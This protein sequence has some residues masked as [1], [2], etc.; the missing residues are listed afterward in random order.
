MYKLS[1]GDRSLN[2]PKAEEAKLGTIKI[3]A[4]EKK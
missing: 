1:S 4:K 2:I 3:K